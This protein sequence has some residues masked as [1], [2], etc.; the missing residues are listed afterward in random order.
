MPITQ[1]ELVALKT[2][3]QALQT[4]LRRTSLA[5]LTTGSA[6]GNLEALKEQVL[7]I[8]LSTEQPQ[9]LLLE[10]EWGYLNVPAFQNDENVADATATTVVSNKITAALATID[11]LNG[12]TAQQ[13]SKIEFAGLFAED[14]TDQQIQHYV[15]VAK[16]LTDGTDHF[17]GFTDFADVVAAHADLANYNEV[18]DATA[19]TDHFAGFTD[20][21]AVVAVS[22]LATSLNV[23]IDCALSYR[24]SLAKLTAENKVMLGANEGEQI[25][26][27]NRI[28]KGLENLHQDKIVD[29]F[30]ANV[31]NKNAEDAKADFIAALK[32]ENGIGNILSVEARGD[33]RTLQQKQFDEAAGKLF[34]AMAKVAKKN[35]DGKFIDNSLDLNVSS[36]E[37][38]KAFIYAIIKFGLM[39]PAVLEY[40]GI[41]EKYLKSTRALKNEASAEREGFEKLLASTDIGNE[42]SSNEAKT[43]IANF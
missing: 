26:R 3:L 28:K 16:A 30:N 19:G 8:N 43:V 37:Q 27:I 9:V 42:L 31:Q 17:A 20:F 18:K 22:A 33:A 6:A 11:L 36:Y 10:E 1:T 14:T 38:F 39:M 40:A 7:A 35:Q 25:T 41:G 12:L 34:D 4:Y 29:L 23:A 15:A 13:L 2:K 24:R 21:A 32:T 5:A